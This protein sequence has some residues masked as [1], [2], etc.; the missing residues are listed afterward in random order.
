MGEHL[1]RRS[2][3]SACAGFAMLAETRDDEHADVE[4]GVDDADDDLR[5]CVVVIR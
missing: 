1:V 5:P 2:C 4:E 3:Q